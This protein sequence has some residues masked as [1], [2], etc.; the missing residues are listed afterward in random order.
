VTRD[1]RPHRALF[2]VRMDT[3]RLDDRYTKGTY[4]LANPS[5]HEEDAS[6]KAEQVI[7]LFEDLAIAPHS[8]CD[9]GCGSGGVLAQLSH[10]LHP[11]C[12]LVGY[13]IAGAAI[14][15]AIETHGHTRVRYNVIESL[16]QIEGNFDIILALDV[17]EHLQD[18]IGFLRDIKRLGSQFVFHI[19]LDLCIQSIWDQQLIMARRR[20][21]GHLHH[22]CRSTAIDTLAICGYQPREIRFTASGSVRPPYSWRNSVRRRIVDAAFR[23][24]PK[25][26]VDVFSGFSLLVLADDRRGSKVSVNDPPKD[27]AI[28]G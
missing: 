23:F 4:K 13:D 2:D 14:Q 16:R 10:H 11:T 28:S 12:A 25:A 9:V 17:F 27:P 15:I 6:W 1:L 3:K 22:F 24:W 21:V 20:S 26:T 8:I 19:P 18:Y 5:W 7:N